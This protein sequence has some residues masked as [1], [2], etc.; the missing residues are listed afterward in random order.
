MVLFDELGNFIIGGEL[1]LHTKQ[2]RQIPNE[3]R[4]ERHPDSMQEAREMV[5]R[6]HHTAKIRSMSSSYNCMGMVFANRRTWIDTDY[7]QMI[8]NDDEY[9]LITSPNDVA[10][11]DIVVYRDDS[12]DITHVGLVA[13]VEPELKD[14]TYKITVLSQWGHD[15]EYFH[16]IDDVNLLL[17]SP[18]EYWTDR[19]SVERR[20][21]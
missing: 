18:A 10:K 8:K 4:P 5:E 2:G 16:R 9:Q 6:N 13:D 11:G 12:K 19:R 3:R 7:I 1:K 15:G 14:G 20:N 17:G 21:S